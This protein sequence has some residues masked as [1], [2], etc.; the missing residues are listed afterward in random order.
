M[1]TLHLL[2]KSPFLNNTFN[3]ALIFTHEDDG[4]L[5]TGDAVYALQANTPF[6]MKMKQISATIYALDEDV[7]ARVISPINNDIIIIDY[8]VFVKLCT[9]YKR[10][11]TWS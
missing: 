10:V 9:E 6:L 11:V 5:L 4:I 3:T 2:N 7:V 8:S 1:N